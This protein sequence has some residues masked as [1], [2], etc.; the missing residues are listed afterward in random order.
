M[1]GLG[2]IFYLI[3]LTRLS[4]DGVNSLS[5]FNACFSVAKIKRIYFSGLWI[6]LAI[7][8]LSKAKS[9]LGRCCQLLV[10]SGLDG[11]L[12]AAM[13]NSGVDSSSRLVGQGVSL[14]LQVLLFSGDTFIHLVLQGLCRC[15]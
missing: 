8:R 3:T 9:R 14:E 4:L 6:R 7:T 12:G 2:P 5:S 15:T 1:W 11:D 10:L 13:L